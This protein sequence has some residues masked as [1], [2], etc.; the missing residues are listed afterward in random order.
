MN[1]FI[2][3]S[4]F[5]SMLTLFCF[6][7][8]A[9][10][11][12]PEFQ[13]PEEM[14]WNVDASHSNVAFTVTHLVI[15]EVDGNFKVY[16]GSLRSSKEDFTDAEINFKVDVNSIDTDNGSRDDHLKGD[17][18]FNAAEYPYMTF[19]SKKFK[20]SGGKK[21]T[22]TGDL[23]IRDVTKEVTFDVTYGG[24]IVDPWGNTKSGFKAS[25]TIDRFDYNLRWNAATETGSLV[26][27]RDVE[28][29]LNL[30]FN[31]QQ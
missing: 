10:P 27:G 8:I 3:R 31:L 24:Q 16:E 26:V 29:N 22:L 19:S 4:V 7:A 18:F 9:Q 17:D 14:V 23:T 2:S 15:S 1:Q 28:I 6:A 5:A 13:M 12:A 30:E 20:K 25:T 11:F 21:Y